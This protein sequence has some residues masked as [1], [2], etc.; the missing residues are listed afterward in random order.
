MRR[1][2]QRLKQSP[3]LNEDD[4]GDA[5]DDAVDDDDDGDDEVETASHTCYFQAC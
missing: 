2:L 5:D 3:Q 1:L 4:D